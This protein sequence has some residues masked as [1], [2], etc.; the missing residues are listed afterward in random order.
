[1]F[2][3]CVVVIVVGVVAAAEEEEIVDVDV[4]GGSVI[5]Y[6]SGS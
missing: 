6:V 2:P 4:S 3:F 1:M 5:V